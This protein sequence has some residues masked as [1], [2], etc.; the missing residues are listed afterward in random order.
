MS[1]TIDWCSGEPMPPEVLR[2]AVH[3]QIAGDYR[4]P[5]CY[6]NHH[7]GYTCTSPQGHKDPHVAW[8]LD[9]VYAVWSVEEGRRFSFDKGD[10]IKSEGPPPR[11]LGQ[12]P[13]EGDH[14]S[15]H[16]PRL[17]WLWRDVAEAVERSGL[18]SEYDKLT[19]TLDI[20]G[21]MREYSII[22]TING[23]EVA[24]K[25]KAHSRSEAEQLVNSAGIGSP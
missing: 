5:T 25:V 20:P 8:G 3:A 6:Q 1:A 22:R 7:T 9:E 19:R 12:M 10:V 14:I 17:Q 2:V 23:L 15:Q 24:V 21:R 18:C 4:K 11:K 16:D 13:E